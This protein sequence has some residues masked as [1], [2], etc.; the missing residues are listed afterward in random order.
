MQSASH[1]EMEPKFECDCI[2]W[3]DPRIV[4]VRN[5]FK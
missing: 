3:G 1:V 2:A 5:A 4:K